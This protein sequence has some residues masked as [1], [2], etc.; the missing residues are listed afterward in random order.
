MGYGSRALEL[1]TQYY[2]GQIPN[3]S[4]ADTASQQPETL[5]TEVWITLL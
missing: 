1:L 4:E 5:L 2:E 3:L